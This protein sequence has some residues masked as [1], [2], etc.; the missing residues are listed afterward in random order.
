MV[1][2]YLLAAAAAGLLAAA[3][4]MLAGAGLPLALVSYVAAGLMAMAGIAAFRPTRSR[5]SAQENP[6][7]STSAKPLE[8]A[9]MRILAVDDDP[10]ILELIPQ[11]A[12][13]AGY[14]NT[15]AADSGEAALAM[16]EDPATHFDCL[17][18][19]ITMPGMD[20][21]ELCR[22]LRRMERYQHTPVIMLTARRDAH[23]MGNAYRAGAS[24]YATKP[25][26]IDDLRQRLQAAQEMVR[27]QSIEPPRLPASHSETPRPIAPL[28]PS[29]RQNAATGQSARPPASLLL[30]EIHGLVS[31]SALLNYLTAL[32]REA[33][34]EV[35]ILAIEFDDSRTLFEG[36]PAETLTAML[37]DL[38]AL[39]IGYFGA[40][41]SVMAYTETASLVIA[42]TLVKP[43]SVPM[44]EAD[45][46]RWLACNAPSQ[47]RSGDPLVTFSVAG[48]IDLH[49]TKAARAAA[50]VELITALA[51]TR[52]LEKQDGRAARNRQVAAR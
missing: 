34:P 39:A 26:E 33:L 32:P 28:S 51:Q 41:R 5:R 46:C 12:A 31:E 1:A 3:V 29:P 36:M 19:D 21:V 17:L 9:E 4:A 2:A 40:D 8:A 13:Q 50:T 6:P 10:F 45:F 43:F 24:D 18:V 20:G 7:R 38:A 48:P 52:A 42:T 23:H 16:L 30:R 37:E 25:F 27:R 49:G 47:L 22:R 44:I 14:T 11:I 35:Q 15:T